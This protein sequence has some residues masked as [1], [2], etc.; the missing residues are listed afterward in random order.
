MAAGGVSRIAAADWTR[1]E[2]RGWSGGG[3]LVRD[4]RVASV[5][6]MVVGQHAGEIADRLLVLA[7]RQGHKAA[8]Q[9]QQQ[10]LLRAGRDARLIGF[11]FSKK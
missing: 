9:L 6:Q 1:P 11:S 2:P 4:C 8:R 5:A 7:A 3:G 10:A